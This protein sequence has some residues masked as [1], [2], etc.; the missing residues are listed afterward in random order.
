MDTG[1]V[2]RTIRLDDFAAEGLEAAAAALPPRD[3]IK[4]N[5]YRQLAKLF[6]ESHNPKM[7]TV[8]QAVVPD[9]FEL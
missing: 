2:I 1:P 5:N 8:G 7:I 6:R 3:K 4:A 9:L